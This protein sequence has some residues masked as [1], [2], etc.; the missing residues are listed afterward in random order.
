MY[1]NYKLDQAMIGVSSNRKKDRINFKE[2]SLIT[3]TTNSFVG[4]VP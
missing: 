2:G 4:K 3:K 1:S